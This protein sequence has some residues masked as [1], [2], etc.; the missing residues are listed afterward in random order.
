[1]RETIALQLRDAAKLLAWAQETLDTTHPHIQDRLYDAQRQL[2]RKMTL[3]RLQDLSAQVHSLAA[4]I[5]AILPKETPTRTTLETAKMGGNDRENERHYQNTNSELKESESARTSQDQIR[6]TQ[7]T[8]SEADQNLPLDLILKAAPEIGSFQPEPIR[9]WRGLLDAAEAIRP[10]LGIPPDV[11]LHAKQAMG[12][13]TAAAA[14]ACMVQRIG[15]IRQP[16]AYLRDLAQKSEQAEFSIAR[17]VM[18]LL[19]A[20]QM[21][22]A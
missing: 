4:D 17:M 6:V 3:P 15:S 14:L 9:T 10:M 13:A 2:R 8:A 5:N 21:Q 18:A 20:D 19:R 12:P 1:M 22:R 16:G 7:G 11:W